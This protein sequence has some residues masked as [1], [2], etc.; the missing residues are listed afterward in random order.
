MA[1]E[2][3]PLGRRLWRVAHG[4]HGRLTLKH[5]GAVREQRR[6]VSV[7]SNT[8]ERNVET[9]KTVFAI[10]ELSEGSRVYAGSLVQIDPRV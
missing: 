7:G 4:D 1:G 6:G 5:F 3:Q 9:G 2:A 10:P 8:E